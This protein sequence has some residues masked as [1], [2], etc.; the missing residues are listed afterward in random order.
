MQALIIYLINLVHH[1]IVDLVSL[2]ASVHLR[3]S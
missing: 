1:Q 2:L 3:I